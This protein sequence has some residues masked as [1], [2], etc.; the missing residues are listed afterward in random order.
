MAEQTENNARIESRVLG[1]IGV[2]FADKN[3]RIYSSGSIASWISF[4]IQLVAVSWLTWELTESTLWLAI[5]ALLDIIP[6]VLLMPFTGVIADRYDRHKIMVYVCSLSLLQA[7]ALAACSWAGVLGIGLLAVLVFI[8]SVLI[9]FM[10]PAMYGVLPRF[11]S[12]P[13]LPSAIAVASS[14]VQVAVFA[15]PALAGWIIISFGVSWAFFVNALGYVFITLAFLRL[16]TPSDYTQELPESGSVFE[17]IRD[18]AAYLIKDKRILT[19]LILGVTVNAMTMGTFHM[20]PAYSELILGMGVEGMSI[21]LAVEG[22]GA[23]ATALWMARGSVNMATPSRVVWSVLI[24]VIA[25]TAIIC[26]ANIY[27]VVAISL[28]LGVAAEIRK[29]GT[30]TIVQ[31]SVEETQRGRVMGTWYMF[32]QIAGGI[33]AYGIGQAAVSFGLQLPT[34]IAAGLCIVLWLVIYINRHQL[35]DQYH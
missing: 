31:M 12:K 3:F 13:V 6:G 22:I 14:Y 19:F 10:V 21:V 9:A 18:G 35:I 8:H 32:S 25:A 5:M 20:L 11:V 27:A 34:V 23:T 7:A 16:K 28:V 15:G 1:G 26:T 33:G 2:A 29:T 4:F 17:H 30:M 24:A